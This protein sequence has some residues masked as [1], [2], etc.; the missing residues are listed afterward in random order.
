[1][2]VQLLLSFTV[3][4]PLQSDDPLA[5]Y[6]KDAVARWETDIQAL[7]QLDRTETDPERAVLFL[8]SSSI[9]RWDSIAQDMA[10]YP[11][12]RRGYGGAKYSDL[13]VFI[14]RLVKS[15]KFSAA[16]IFVGNDVAGKEDDKSPEEVL[17]LVRICVA[18]IHEHQPHA[19][20]FL[21]SITPTPA[22]FAAWDKIKQVNATLAKY[23]NAEEGLHFINTADEYLN[24]QGKPIAEYFG[25]DHLHQNQ[26]GYQVWSRIIKDGLRSA[27]PTQRSDANWK[28]NY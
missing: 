9:R 20:V 3:L 4:F 5:Q 7:E 27:L 2:L 24:S 6:R 22:R 18:Q 17:R 23:C 14:D 13:A 21:I 15:H 10:P 8:G 28:Q 11:V 26:A 25:D 19:A 1:M 16:A 12:I